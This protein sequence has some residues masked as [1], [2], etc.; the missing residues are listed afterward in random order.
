MVGTQ[1]RMEI[2]I[3]G[4]VVGWDKGTRGGGRDSSW[5]PGVGSLLG[6]LNG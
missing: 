1:V 5:V 4:Q 2:R 3:E 6:S